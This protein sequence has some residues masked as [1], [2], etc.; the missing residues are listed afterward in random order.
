MPHLPEHSLERY[1][2]DLTSGEEDA[3]VETHL[4]ACNDCCSRLLDIERSL[5]A[6]RTSPTEGREV[7]FAV[8]ETSKGAVGLIV[9]P[10][11]RGKWIA[12]ILG[13]ESAGE[14]TFKSRGEAEHYCRSTF[15]EIFPGHTCT[16]GCRSHLG[17]ESD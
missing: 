2:L 6:E 14:A 15:S 5:R 1:A 10:G 16:G 4:Q 8:H 17:E 7:L 12:R 9:R 11:S 13:P 3:A